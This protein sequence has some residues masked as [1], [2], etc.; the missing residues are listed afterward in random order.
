MSTSYRPTIAEQRQFWDW[1]WENWQERGTINEWKEKRHE[2]ILI[3]LRS[4]SLDRP[5]ILDLGCGP[6]WYTAKLADF[7][8]TV[9][10]DLSEEAIR[11]AKT[12]FPQIVFFAGN[13]FELPLP[14]EGFDV[15][16]SQEVIDHVEDPRRF[17]DRAAYLLKPGG[18]LIVSCANKFVMDRLGDEAFPRQPSAH[19]GRYLDLK[20]WKKLLNDHFHVR[21]AKTI[22]PIGNGGILRLINSYKLNKGIGY[23]IPRPYLD[24]L[25]EHAGFGYQIILLGQKKY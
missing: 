25:K 6:G 12:R 17:L 13:L 16:V 5:R 11:M 19:I 2:M 15:I 14:K 4:L 23:V 18:H 22:L 10:V 8:E 24:T 7:G 3:F 20:S 1:H 21:R 9:G